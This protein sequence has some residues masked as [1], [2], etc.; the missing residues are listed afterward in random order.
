MERW[1]EW[2]E[3]KWVGGWVGRLPVRMV[4]PPPVNMTMPATAM[5]MAMLCHCYWVNGL[6]FCVERLDW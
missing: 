3:R 5:D 1:V 6:G 2:E 4:T